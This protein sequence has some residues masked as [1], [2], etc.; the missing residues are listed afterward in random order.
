MRLLVEVFN[1]GDL[2]HILIKYDKSIANI[3]V[4]PYFD[5]IMMEFEAL[6]GSGEYSEHLQKIDFTLYKELQIRTLM[7]IIMCL[8]IGQKE[9]AKTLIE[10]FNFKI[11]LNDKKIIDREAIKKAENRIKKIETSLE[12]QKI[13]DDRQKKDDKVVTWEKM[14]VKIHVGLSI[15]PENDCSVTQYLEYENYL[16]EVTA[17]KKAS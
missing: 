14:R 13:E 12:I 17:S 1:T 15:M 10:N 6:K 8:K 2:R 16:K 5:V 11:I 3:D 4:S 7:F 9:D